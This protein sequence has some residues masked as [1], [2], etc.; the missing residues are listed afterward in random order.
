MSALAVL[1]GCYCVQVQRDVGEGK[2]LLFGFLLIFT[3]Y[4]ILAT[5]SVSEAI[6][7]KKDGPSDNTSNGVG[8]A[9]LAIFFM[10]AY[11]IPITYKVHTYDV[12]GAYGT[13]LLAIAYLWGNLG[14]VR[15]ARIG[16]G[17]LVLYYVFGTLHYT[18][19][20][21]FL[22]FSNMAS[23]LILAC[24]YVGKTSSSEIQP[25]LDETK[26]SSILS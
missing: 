21:G 20:G 12:F 2:D 5:Q 25:P 17:S 19:K 22:G 15:L 6:D 4:V 16:A 18:S 8:Y 10:L 11:V 13:A 23:R 24:M 3:G 9:A 1:A 14:H 7:G 26:S